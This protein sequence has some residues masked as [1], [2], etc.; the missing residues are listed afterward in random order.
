MPPLDFGQEIRFRSFRQTEKPEPKRC[1][2]YYDKNNQ[3]H[4]YQ[5]P[6]KMVTEWLHVLLKLLIL[7]LS[8]GFLAI[9]SLG[10]P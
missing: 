9:P 4:A 8:K 7:S 5:K 6:L 2:D 3:P 10:F 1:P